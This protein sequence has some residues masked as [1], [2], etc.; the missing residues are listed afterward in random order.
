MHLQILCSSDRTEFKLTDF[1]TAIDLP[2][3]GE[4]LDEVKLCCSGKQ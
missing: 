2:A 4:E 3:A 1:G